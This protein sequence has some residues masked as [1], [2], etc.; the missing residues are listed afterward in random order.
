MSSIL[1]KD[2]RKGCTRMTG[3]GASCV[4]ARL[5][6][7]Y[8]VLTWRRSRRNPV[9]LSLPSTV[10]LLHSTSPTAVSVCATR[11]SSSALSTTQKSRKIGINLSR[12]RIL[13]VSGSTS[14]TVRRTP[15]SSHEAGWSS[16]TQIT[17]L[18]P[19][20]KRKLR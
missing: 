1:G 15:A 9:I 4:G 16:R 11:E 7:S 6:H 19:K 17:F 12:Q 18:V 2:L 8:S 5:T 3:R 10:T 20:R 13:L 14:A